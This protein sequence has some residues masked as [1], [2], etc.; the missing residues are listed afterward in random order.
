MFGAFYFGQAYFGQGSTQIAA[1]L[2]ILAT[3]SIAPRIA[4]AIQLDP[5]LADASIEL[6]PLLDISES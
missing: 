2:S 5:A 4:C 3:V 6:T 1:L